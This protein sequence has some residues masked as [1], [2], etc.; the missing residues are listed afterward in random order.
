MA[1]YCLAEICKYTG[2]KEEIIRDRLM[3]GIRDKS[4]SELYSKVK[5]NN[6]TKTTEN[7]QLCPNNVPGEEGEFTKETNVQH[8]MPYV[9]V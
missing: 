4:L 5:Q 3:V 9:T 6:L 8:V 2:L 1:L 7:Q